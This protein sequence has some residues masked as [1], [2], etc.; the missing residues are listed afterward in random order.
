MQLKF[1]NIEILH[2]QF[3]LYFQFNNQKNYN[4]YILL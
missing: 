4:Q 2:D 3:L 1:E